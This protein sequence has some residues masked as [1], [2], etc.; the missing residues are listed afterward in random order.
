MVSVSS[1]VNVFEQTTNS[2]RA[3]STCS[4]TSAS[5]TPSTFDTQCR[6]IVRLRYRAERL[7]RHDD[8]EIGAADADV[9]DVGEAARRVAR[10]PAFVHARDEVAHLAELART[11]GMTSW[12][13]T[14]IGRSERLRSAMCRPARFSV[15]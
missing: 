7:G 3:G 2:V 13:S 5:C 15:S 9:D 11:S 6:R 8:A 12:P 14:S 1:V 10:D 4:S